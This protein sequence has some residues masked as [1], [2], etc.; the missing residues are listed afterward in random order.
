MN[1]R[2]SWSDKALKDLRRMACTFMFDANKANK[3]LHA[4][5]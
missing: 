4:F 2:V 3:P 1:Y 5:A